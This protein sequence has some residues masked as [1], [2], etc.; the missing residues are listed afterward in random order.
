MTRPARPTAQQIEGY[1]AA[2]AEKAAAA[3]KQLAAAEKRRAAGDALATLDVYAARLQAVGCQRD[4]AQLSAD[5]LGA[6]AEEQ[7]QHVVRLV[8]AGAKPAEVRDAEHRLGELEAELRSPRHR[9]SVGVATSAMAALKAEREA[10][11]RAAWDDMAGQLRAEGEA[12]AARVDDLDKARAELAAEW[13]ALDA[14][15][16]RLERAAGGPAFRGRQSLPPFPLP[17]GDAATR[18]WPGGGRAFDGSRDPIPPGMPLGVT[19]AEADTSVPGIPAQ[20]GRPA[21]WGGGRRDKPA[22]K[23]GPLDALQPA[24]AD[25]DD[26]PDLEPAA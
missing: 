2:N 9:H 23:P 10:A 7:R 3:A 11:A 4:A 24:P 21:D 1:I 8:A 16:Q 26:V 13:Q 18:P 22:G 14:R 25:T 19:M 17:A 15:W 6:Q 12:L 20:A 5:L